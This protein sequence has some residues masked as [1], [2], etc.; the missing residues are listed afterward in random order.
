MRSTKIPSGFGLAEGEIPYWYGRMSW[1]ANWLLILLGALN[2]LLFIESKLQ[3]WIFGL[4]GILFIL[5]ATLRIYTSEYFMTNRRIYVKYGLI[6][7]RIFEIKIEWV[8]G[9]HV[10]QG[11][12]GRLLNYGD[13]IISTPGFYA[14]FV[15]M[16]GVS[17]PM[18][19]RIMVEDILWRAR[20]RARVEEKIRELEKEYE[21]GRISKEKYLELRKKYEEELKKYL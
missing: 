15:V 19:I 12:M 6:A 4:L 8:V 21:F 5:I 16:R 10:S 9:T 17:D 13:I 18:H 3:I 11:L 2:L 7:R 20:E 14:G 1:R